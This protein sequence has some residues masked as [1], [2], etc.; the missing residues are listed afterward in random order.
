MYGL[1]WLSYNNTDQTLSWKGP[2][3]ASGEK[4][5]AREKMESSNHQINVCDQNIK[6]IEEKVFGDGLIV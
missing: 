6:K 5:V 3:S 1:L 4:K 2:V